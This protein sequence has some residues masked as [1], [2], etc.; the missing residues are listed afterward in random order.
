MGDRYRE[1]CPDDNCPNLFERCVKQNGGFR[2]KNPAT[3]PALERSISRQLDRKN[4]DGKRDEDL[5]TR[6]KLAM[7]NNSSDFLARMENTM[8]LCLDNSD[9]PNN[10][11]TCGGSC[12]NG[13]FTF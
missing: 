10:T 3:E 12:A 5:L 6:L 13:W 1:R 4:G 2:G 11:L 8:S 9:V 7:E